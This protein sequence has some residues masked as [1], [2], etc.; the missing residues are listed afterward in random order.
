[1]SVN[2]NFHV[3]P[4]Y[5]SLRNQAVLYHFKMSLSK[6]TYSLGQ[7]LR[8]TPPL[9][10]RDADAS[11]LLIFDI[12][13]LYLQH[14]VHTFAWVIRSRND[15]GRQVDFVQVG[16]VIGVSRERGEI[17]FQL[18]AESDAIVMNDIDEMNDVCIYWLYK[19]DCNLHQ[20]PEVQHILTH[21]APQSAVRVSPQDPRYLA[22]V[23][24]T[25]VWG[26]PVFFNG[27]Y[28]YNLPNAMGFGAAVHAGTQ[29]SLFVA[30][31]EYRVTLR[32]V[33]DDLQGVIRDATGRPNWELGETAAALAVARGHPGG[34]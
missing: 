14:R 15:R 27:R 7:G 30:G 2:E 34:L 26:S 20:T 22:N 10:F 13:N 19:I 1:M 16:M 18:T 21:G 31:Q 23:P 28:V 6:P 4:M 25:D 5:L 12:M 11:R 29:V 9:S 24:E 33:V 32:D 3:C 8:A 17:L